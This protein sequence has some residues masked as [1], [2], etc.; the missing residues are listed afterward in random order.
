[1]PTTKLVFLNTSWVTN[2]STTDP[3]EVSMYILYDFD[4][5]VLR[6]K[7]DK[8]VLPTKVGF[9]SDKSYNIFGSARSWLFWSYVC[10]LKP[11]TRPDIVVFTEAESIGDFEAEGGS[12]LVGVEGE[13]EGE[14][15]G[16]VGSDIVVEGT[17]VGVIEAIF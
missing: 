15:E 11:N 3:I 7:T 2:P 13:G 10:S 17:Y 9:V 12:K 14:D 8:V 1:M 6:I 16:G 4:N 5:E